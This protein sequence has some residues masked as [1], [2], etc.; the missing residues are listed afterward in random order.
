MRL[1]S[2][3]RSRHRRA[4][5]ASR[6]SMVSKCLLASG[7]AAKVVRYDRN[8]PTLRWIKTIRVYDQS[9]SSAGSQAQSDTNGPDQNRGWDRDQDRQR[10]PN[11][12]DQW[13]GQG[14]GMGAP[15]T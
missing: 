5:T 12:R 7:S 8:P 4:T 15:G 10:Q 2:K 1:R 9:G 6:S 13:G 3:F 11:W 14:G